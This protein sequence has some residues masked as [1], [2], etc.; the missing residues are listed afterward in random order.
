MARPRPIP[1]PESAQSPSGRLRVFGNKPFLRFA[2][3]FGA[4]D[5]DLWEAFQEEPDADL[6]GQ[7]FKFRLARAGE[8]TSGGART[9]VAMRRNQ[10]I[11]MMFGFEKKDTANISAKDLK[12]FK[13][14]SK[15]Y[16]ELSDAEMEKLVK[17]SELV[18]IEAPLAEEVRRKGKE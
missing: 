13:K 16:L 14:L 9:I 4:S 3:K 12:G 6:G 5:R 15:I 17:S 18:E 11:V 2:R 7:V 8:G 1:A 10:R